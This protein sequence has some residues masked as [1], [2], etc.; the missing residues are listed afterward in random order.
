MFRPGGGGLEHKNSN[1]STVV[2]RTPPE[3]RRW[4]SLGLLAHEYF[5]LFNV[6]RLRPVELGPFDFDKQPTTGS[7]WMAEGVTSYYSGLLMTRFGTADARRIS[8]VAVV[9]HRQPAGVSRAA[10]AIRRAVLARR[11]EQQ[12]F[13]GRSERIHGELLQQGQRPRPAPR[14]EYPP[15]HRRPQEL[16]RCDATWPISGIAASAATPRMNCVWSPKAWPAPSFAT[17]SARPCR[18][19]KSSSTAICSSCTAAIRT[20][21]KAAGNWKL[22]VRPDRTDAQKRQMDA[23]LARSQAR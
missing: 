13:R 3:R 12:Q 4:P 9:A 1:L 20:F 14:R 17:G 15:C 11:L 19:P 8:D 5:H 7:L 18:P 6:K 23:W 10:A 16:R 21:G 2:A 22:E